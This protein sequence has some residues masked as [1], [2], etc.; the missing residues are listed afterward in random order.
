METRRRAV[1][2]ALGKLA[3][4]KNFPCSVKDPINNIRTRITTKA[5]ARKTVNCRI[6]PFANPKEITN[7]P[8]TRATM[9]STCF[10]SFPKI[11]DF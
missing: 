1:L 11:P 6:I 7:K 4:S 2:N 3:S 8:T 9:A 10:L 5:T